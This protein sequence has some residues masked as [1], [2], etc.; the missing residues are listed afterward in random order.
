MENT[1]IGQIVANDQ[2]TFRV[3]EH[4]NID[5]YNKGKRS[6]R[7]AAAENE[8]ALP[9]LLSALEKAKAQ[10]PETATDF[11]SW[12]LDELANYIVKT[13]HHYANEQMQEIKP[14]LEKLGEAYGKE[15]PEL[16]DLKELFGIVSGEIAVHQKKEELQLFPFIRRMADAQKN[17]K[18]FVAPPLT[19]SAE[20]PVNMLTHDHQEQGKAF[21]TIRTLTRNY[22][23]AEDALGA[24]KKALLM[25]QEFES[26]LHQHLHLENNILFPKALVLEK[27][28]KQ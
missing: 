12:P 22:T 17:N 13:H 5:F 28:L 2:R 20:N 7:E 11:N 23:P 9:E 3:F 6:L 19:K 14:Y 21:E 16:L 18:E 25:L 1:P 24:Y 8:T 26:N 10:T 15:Q 27:E 4:Y